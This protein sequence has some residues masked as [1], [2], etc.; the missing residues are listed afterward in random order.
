MK[1]RAASAASWRGIWGE[2]RLVFPSRGTG[3]GR[4]RGGGAG[5]PEAR[6][7]KGVRFPEPPLRV[8]PVG[9]LVLRPKP[10]PI[11]LAS[12]FPEGTGRAGTRGFS[13]TERG[14]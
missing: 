1:C 2:G 7:G 14:P 6:P 8:G 5:G 13:P 12:P 9:S 3:E 11:G 10:S 4:E